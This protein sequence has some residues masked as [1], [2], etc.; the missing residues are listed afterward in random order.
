M[1]QEERKPRNASDYL[2]HLRCK[3]F[4]L[5]GGGKPAIILALGAPHIIITVGALMLQ[6][7]PVGFLAAVVGLALVLYT[8]LAAYWL[9]K[10]R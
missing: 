9:W 8:G 5:R 4:S 6:A 3:Q 1:A 2:F 10:D 7:L